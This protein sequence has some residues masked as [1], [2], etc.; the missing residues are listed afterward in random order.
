MLTLYCYNIKISQWLLVLR[1]VTSS[2]KVDKQ[3]R[4]AAFRLACLP[5]PGCEFF[6][7]FRER[8]YGSANLH[9]DWAQSYNDAKI[10][11]PPVVSSFATE[12]HENFT[13]NPFMTALPSTLHSVA[14]NSNGNGSHSILVQT[15]SKST[16]SYSNGS[17]AAN[18]IENGFQNSSKA[19]ASSATNTSPPRA[20]GASINGQQPLNLN[21]NDYQKWDL[22]DIT[23]NYLQLLLHYIKDSNGG[24]LVHCISG[25]D[26]TPLF[27]SLLRISLWADGA[28]HQT[29]TAI[30]LLYY[31]L[32]YD[33]YM[34]G[35]NLPDRLRKGE[36]IFFFCFYMLKHIEGIE[37]ST[38][39]IK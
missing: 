37:Y 34:F 28:I 32:A 23:L 33:W 30:Q 4:Y 16:S 38:V 12:N 2:E 8:G 39:N 7:K 17:M 26:R 36:D 21:W 3:N 19:S 18:S 20:C 31:T 6:R 1:S 25:W 10:H 27:V 24:L 9:Y 29:L 22:Q 13:T 11:V 35:H 14:S 5:Y 15:Q